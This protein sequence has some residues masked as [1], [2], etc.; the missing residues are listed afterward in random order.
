MNY[1]FPFLISIAVPKKTRISGQ[2]ADLKVV[3]FIVSLHKN[4]HRK[5]EMWNA[6]YVDLNGCSKN[7]Y[8]SIIQHGKD[9][10]FRLACEWRK[11]QIELLN[12]QGAGYT[13][14]HGT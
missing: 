1:Q 11:E 9:E 14:R 2:I 4:K 8:F 7:K 3:K 12:L 13:E 5:S 6:H 10:A